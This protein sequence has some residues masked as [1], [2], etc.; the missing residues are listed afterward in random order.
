MI[1]RPLAPFG[2]E[3]IGLDWTS[4]RVDHCALAELVARHRVLVLR[5]RRGD[6]QAFTALLGGFGPLVFTEGEVPV[7][8]APL[9]N[10]VTNV[11]RS[12]PPVSRFHTDSSYFACPPALTALR[13]VQVPES[14]GTTVF[15]DQVR[16]AAG[17]P[18][19]WRQCLDGRRVLHRCTG[20]DG[21]DEQNWHPLFRCHP[22]TG[23]TA[24][25]LSTPARCIAIDGIDAEP[26]RRI[27]AI[28]YRRS[29]PAAG[30]YRH[31]WRP[32]DLLIWDNRV[33]MHRADHDGVSGPRTL[34]RGMVAGEAPTAARSLLS[35]ETVRS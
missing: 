2:A 32:D 16:A 21:I 18:R 28:L 20:L 27:L 17:L 3:I 29:Q 7:P 12:V 8:G 4:G 15:S 6:D 30:L 13:P 9:L 34:H 11:G 35:G 5:G 1:V 14:G 22:I 31:A 24:L 19:R 23:E 33:T 26:A 10:I 25:Y